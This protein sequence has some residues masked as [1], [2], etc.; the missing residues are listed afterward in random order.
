MFES[1]FN[2]IGR[3]TQDAYIR[4]EKYDDYPVQVV[5]KDS[6]NNTWN[7]WESVFDTWLPRFEEAGW[8]DGLNRIEVGNRMI[9]GERVG[10]YTRD[11][12]IIRLKDE[13]V[14]FDTSYLVSYTKEYLLIHEAIHHVHMRDIF[15]FDGEVDD[16]ALSQKHDEFQWYEEAHDFYIHVS[17]YASTNFLEAVAETGAGLCL[18]EEYPEHIT[19]TYKMFGGPEPL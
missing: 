18:G 14:M 5:Y 7:E 6:G 8:L 15:G 1:A 3:A 16:V 9:N 19:E 10:E 2:R 4:P 17:E 11:E 12:R 13:P